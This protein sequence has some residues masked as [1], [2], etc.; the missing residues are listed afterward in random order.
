MAK[1]SKAKKTPER[2]EFAIKDLKPHPRQQASFAPPSEAQVDE[3]AKDIEARG[4]DHPIHILPDGTILSGHTRVLAY[5]RLGRTHIPVII[6]WDLVEA[7][8]LAQMQFVI[9]ENTKRRQLNPLATAR[10]AKV[11]FD[12]TPREQRPRGGRLREWIAKQVG[13]VSDRHI[14]RLLNLLKLPQPLLDAI[15]RNEVSM[16]DGY[17]L[18]RKREAQTTALR[19]IE[20]HT[21]AAEAVKQALGKAPKIQRTLGERTTKRM[22]DLQWSISRLH[23]SI[24]GMSGLQVAVID[25]LME[26]LAELKRAAGQRVPR[27]RHS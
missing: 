22:Q 24:H 16:A 13:G 21:I 26:E 19:L 8:E 4:L 12:A 17:A 7:G 10:A 15:S 9:S 23:G 5:R 18:L 2:C 20:E 11:L 1:A 25:Q 3:M 27:K 6:R 14:A